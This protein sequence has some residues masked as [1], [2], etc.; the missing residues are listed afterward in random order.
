MAESKL[1]YEDLLAKTGG[2]SLKNTVKVLTAMRMVRLWDGMSVDDILDEYVTGRCVRPDRDNTAE[3]NKAY[4]AMLGEMRGDP[5]FEELSEQLM[6]V[7]K[8]E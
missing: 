2:V 3:C 5:E 6:M 8:L 1:R 7:G 4:I